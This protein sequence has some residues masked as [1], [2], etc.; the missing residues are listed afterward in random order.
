MEPLVVRLARNSRHQGVEHYCQSPLVFTHLLAHH[1]LHRL[2]GGLPVDVPHVVGGVIAANTVEVVARSA[3]VTLNPPRKH[4][5]RM[6]KIIKRLRPRVDEYFA[7]S[8][9]SS[10]LFEEP[11]RELRCYSKSGYR[12]AAAPLEGVLGALTDARVG[13]REDKIGKLAQ[14]A[15]PGRWGDGARGRRGE[16]SRSVPPS[17]PRPLAVSPRHAVGL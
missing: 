8:I 4:R 17:F 5:Q 10:P 15:S 16:R 14:P 7:G 13:G 9:D 12:V 3:R 6:I 1:H 11:S 2:G